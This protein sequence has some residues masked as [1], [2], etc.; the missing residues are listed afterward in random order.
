MLH[1]R[2]KTASRVDADPI[3]EF[4]EK[5]SDE[6]SHRREIPNDEKHFLWPNLS[7]LI[8]GLPRMFGWIK[9]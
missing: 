1:S 7:S 9:S 3:V 4:L 8:W 2:N 5:H 6:P